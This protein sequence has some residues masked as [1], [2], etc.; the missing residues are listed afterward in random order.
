MKQIEIPEIN[1]IIEAAKTTKI[2]YSIG[3]INN[4]SCHVLTSFEV[5]EITNWL[6]G[7]IGVNTLTYS[8]LSPLEYA[9]LNDSK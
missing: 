8:V 3:F 7:I 2:R 1:K 9:T 6:L 5:A 4:S